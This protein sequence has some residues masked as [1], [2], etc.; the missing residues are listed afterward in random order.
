[1]TYN[2]FGG[3]LILAQ[4]LNNLVIHSALCDWCIAPKY[5]HLFL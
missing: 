2:V 4:Q 3:T 1:M 5:S